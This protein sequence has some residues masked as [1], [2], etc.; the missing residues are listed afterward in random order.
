ML[1]APPPTG[2][3]ATRTSGRLTSSGAL[4]RGAIQKRGTTP[5][6][7][8]KDGDIPMGAA[9]AGSRGSGSG[10]GAA[11][12]GSASSRRHDPLSGRPSRPSKTGINASAIEK[13]VLRSMGSDTS[14]SKGPRSSLRGVRGRDRI[15]AI[16]E[17]LE[18][19]SV[20]GLKQSKAAGNPDGGVSDLIGFLERKAT[21]PDAPAR[22]AVKIK[23]SRLEGDILIIS[24]RP[25]DTPKIMRLNTYMFAGSTLTIKGPLGKTA[26]LESN[27]ESE[28][29]NT[30]NILKGVLSRRYNVDTKLLDLSQLGSDPELVNIGMFNT[31]SRESKFFPALMKICDSIFTTAHQKEEAVVSVSLANNAL[32]NVTSVTTLA[33]TFPAIKNLD[34]SNNNL[35]ALAALD[36]WRWKFRKLD[37]LVLTGNPLETE[38]PS[39]KDDMLK[40]FPSLTALNTIQI[41]SPEDVKLAANGKLPIP[42]LGP[43]FRD[44]AS[45]SENFVKQFFAAY[46]LDRAALVNGYYDAQSTFS[47]SINTSA[48]RAP[49]LTDQKIPS[50]DSYIKRSRNLTKVT[51]LPARVSRIYTGTE[52]I[53]DA[54]TTLPATRHPDLMGEPQKWC[55]ECHAIPGLPDPSGQSVSGV[56]GL[57]VMV[58]G[59]FAEINVSTGESN[60]TRSFDRTFV[61]GPGGGIGGIRVACDTL[62]L[63]SYGGHEAWQPEVVDMPTTQSVQP[64]VGYQIPVPPGFAV[65][66]PGKTGEQ[67]QKE[68]LAVELS[69]GTGMT[70]EYSHM[71]LEQSKFDLEA[72]TRAFEQAKPQLPVEAFV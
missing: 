50:W 21:D 40:W 38:V 33:Q 4:S 19:I 67:V 2:P 53:R 60:V 30:I 63:R 52:V 29:P 41:R 8:D 14:V 26:P 10:R 61:L 55:I 48:P 7:V 49:E 3:K 69:K 28:T 18:R 58:H 15:G 36:S 51:H 5:A 11:I 54:F 44:E 66:G 47:L 24:V 32:P 65:V 64:Q 6:R 45:I 20:I 9:G 70:L 17:S 68:V 35:K 56:G 22:E 25:E 12:R 34:L 37:H 57:I 16:R 72:A 23:K 46:D 43:S 1:Q 59:Q 27:A 31:T 62:V 71:C 13:T 39:Y 42:I